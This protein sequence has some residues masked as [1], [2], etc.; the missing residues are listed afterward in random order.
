MKDKFA[1]EM[2][3][4]L[5]DKTPKEILDIVKIWA[6]SQVNIRIINYDEYNHLANKEQFIAII[7]NDNIKEIAELNGILQ[8]NIAILLIEM[9]KLKNKK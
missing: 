6:E 8:A 7:E 1:Y 5:K 3:D 4:D 2:V 9:I